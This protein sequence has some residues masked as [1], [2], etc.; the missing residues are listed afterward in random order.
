MQKS[1]IE[2]IIKELATYNAEAYPESY[3]FH[4]EG[5]SEACTGIE[6]LANAYFDNRTEGEVERDEAAGVT[7]EDYTRWCNEA[8]NEALNP[9]A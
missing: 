7:I 1:N 4:V 2:T 3:P 6:S 9:D 5:K 8:V